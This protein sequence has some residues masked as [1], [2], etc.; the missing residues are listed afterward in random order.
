[1]PSSDLHAWHVRQI[2]SFDNQELNDLL[3]SHWGE[4]RETAGDRREQVAMW[5]KEL[6][7]KVLAKA[8]LGNGRR[9][10]AKTCQN[11]HR[12][13]GIGGQIGPDITGSNRA[14]PDYI[15]EN[16]LDPGAVVGRDYQM[17]VVALRDGRSIS[18]L[19]RQETDS[20]S[21]N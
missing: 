9:I 14:N 12:L 4:I 3:K 13:F 10:F 17:T 20:A 11:C 2:L 1:M 15:L 19:L 6:T 5:K 16:I 8:N 7:P 18:G 21:D